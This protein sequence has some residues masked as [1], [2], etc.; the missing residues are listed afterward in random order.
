MKEKHSEKISDIQKMEHSSPK[1][2]KLCLF[3]KAIFLYWRRELA[4]PGKQK[5]SNYFLYFSKKKD[6]IWHFGMTADEAVK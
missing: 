2:K 3:L 4:K 6:D 5:N 1:L